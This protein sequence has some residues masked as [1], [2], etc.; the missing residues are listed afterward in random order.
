MR[1]SSQ[2][3][4]RTPLLAAN[5]KMHKTIEETERFLAEFL[6]AVAETPGPRS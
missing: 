1:R 4:E 5:W 6:P 2:M 3:A